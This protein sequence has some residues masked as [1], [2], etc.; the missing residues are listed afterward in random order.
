[1]A[2]LYLLEELS[3]RLTFLVLG[4]TPDSQSS[5][6]SSGRQSCYKAFPGLLSVFV[7]FLLLTVQPAASQAPPTSTFK[8]TP[9][10]PTAA[11]LGKYLD[12]PVTLATG[13]PQ[14]N[15]PLYEIKSGEL[16]L[17]ISL[18]YQAT[19]F[20]VSERAGWNGL[21][22]SLNAGG[23]ISR[24][25]RDKKDDGSFEASRAHHGWGDYQLNT[26]DETTNDGYQ[27]LNTLMDSG[28]LPDG[29][30]DLFSFSYP[31]HSGRFVR[32]TINSRVLYHRG[33][34]HLR[35]GSVGA[36]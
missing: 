1:M 32:P 19:G 23:L 35:Y 31:G 20:R 13:T 2:Y 11:S 27:Y 18:S 4:R 14:I 16:T 6:L 8:I 7:L 25:I 5:W 34:S 21:G 3:K 12:L 33:N 28:T 24:T 10:S 29:Q 22:W 17:P 30:P 9:H 36:S 26:L 15:I